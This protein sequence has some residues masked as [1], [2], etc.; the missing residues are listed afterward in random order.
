MKVAKGIL[1]ARVVKL[2][3]A[4]SAGIL[5]GASCAF[6]VFD[7]VHRGHQFLIGCAKMDA[8]ERGVPSAVLTFSVDPDELF[9]PD[10]LVKL[11]SN[12]ERIVTLAATGVDIVAVLP[13]DCAFAALSPIEFLESTFGE[14]P[15][16]SMH[17]GEGFR[18]GSRGSGDARLLAEWGKQF[19][20][21]VSVHELLD[22][23][24]APVSSSR[25]RK[26]LAEGRSREA[27][28]LL[29]HDTQ[30]AAC[31]GKAGAKPGLLARK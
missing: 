1:M 19:G 31:Q 13:F 22:M 26:L 14:K 12:E 2:E 6:G 25:I 28:R 4:G 10:R 30:E 11:M 20:M 27:E 23:Y 7:G 29:G 17:V 15:P 24:G 8:M 21:Y 3:R 18:F 5:A 16:A 9:A